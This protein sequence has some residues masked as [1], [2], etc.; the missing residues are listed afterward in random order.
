M[1]RY[2]KM[3]E[4]NLLELIGSDVSE[5]EGKLK[6][7]IKGET[8]YYQVYKIPLNSPFY[9]DRNGRIA[10]NISKYNDENGVLNIEDI[11]SYNDVIHEFIV[12]SNKQALQD[13][14]KNIKDFGQRKAGVVLKN[15]RIID[16][17]RRFTCLRELAKESGKDY[18]FEAVILDT[19]NGITEKDIKRLELN[20]QHAEEK[21]VDYNP[22]DNLVDIYKDLVENSIFTD[23][24]YATST[25]KKLREVEKLKAEAILMVEFL[26]FINVKGKYFIARDLKLDGPLQE[27]MSILKKVSDE[28]KQDVKYALFSAMVTSENGDLTRHIRTIGNDVIKTDRVNEFLEEYEDVVEAVHDTLH[29]EDIPDMAKINQVLTNDKKIKEA[30]KAGNKIIDRQVEVNRTTAA[31]NKPID[32][33]GRA[34]DIV[35]N[36]DTIAVSRMNESNQQELKEILDKLQAAVSL[37]NGKLNV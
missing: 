15:G 23:Q 16:G 1:R 36:I 8:K 17:N 20:L 31:R 28:Q 19:D 33:L 26:E 11:D 27:M 6:L 9:N 10:T 12:A 32:E 37:L 18:Y 24:E 29:E 3:I 13:T 21:P 34:F 7:T 25:N 5:T 2:M 22:I 30:K 35:D 14:K 4:T